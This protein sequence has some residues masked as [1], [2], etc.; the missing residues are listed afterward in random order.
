VG[1]GLLL[2][3]VQAAQES[4]RRTQS[5]NNLKQIAL[6]LHNFH[7]V[8]GRFPTGTHANEKLEPEQRLSWM[9]DVLPFLEASNVFNQIDFK[10]PWDGDANRGPLQVEIQQLHNP[11]IAAPQTIPY[12]TT[13]YVGIAGLGEDA[14]KLPVAHE[15]AGAFGYD[16][17]VRIQDIRDGTSNTMGVTESS[18]DFGAWGAGGKATIR[19][20]TAKPYINGPDG[21]GGPYK[22]G[23]NVMMMD[24]S[25]RFVSENIDPKALEAL[26]TINGGEVP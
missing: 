14:P 8:Y 10:E 7:D 1:T 5:M 6:A 4:A 2:P 19:A 25:V 15:R 9:A 20:L 3:A 23:M 22:G 18:K 11:G 13:H 16:R 24:G 26:S 21:L 12:A 17:T